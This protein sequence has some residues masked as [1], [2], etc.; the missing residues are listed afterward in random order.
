VLVGGA[1]LLALELIERPTED[2][3]FFTDD[4][5]RIADAVNALVAVAGRNGWLVE[6]LRSTPTFHRLQWT[7]NDETVRVDVASTHRRACHDRRSS[8]S[9]A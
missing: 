8:R 2:L 1:A 9:D 7:C 5:T 3:D 4:P 6:P